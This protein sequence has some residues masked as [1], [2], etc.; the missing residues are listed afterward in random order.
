[1]AEHEFPFADHANRLAHMP[2][3]LPGYQ[4]IV[5]RPG[6]WQWLMDFLGDRRSGRG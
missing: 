4:P 3:M 1:M 2:W 5:R 6:L